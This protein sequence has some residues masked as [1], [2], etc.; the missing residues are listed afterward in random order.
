M[1]VLLASYNV[2]QL[3]RFLLN[4]F[5][6]YIYISIYIN[7]PQTLNMSVTKTACHTFHD[8]KETF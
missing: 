7:T 5:Y 1:L 3:L 8:V 6:Y 2:F 4:R